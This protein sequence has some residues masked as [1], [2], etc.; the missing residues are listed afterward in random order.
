MKVKQI[1]RRTVRM[2]GHQ[3]WEYITATPNEDNPKMFYIR[4]FKPCRTYAS[5]CTN[6][7]AALFPRLHGRFPYSMAEFNAFEQQQQDKVRIA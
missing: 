3:R 5:Y 4:H 1:K 7:N 2:M 6:C